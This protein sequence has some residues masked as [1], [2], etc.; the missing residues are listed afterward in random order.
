KRHGGQGFHMVGS[1]NHHFVRA[2]PVH[3]IEHSFG[4]RSSSPS[5]P[6][7]GNL[8]GMTRKFQAPSPGW[9]SLTARYTMISGG[10]LLSLPGQ[11]GQ[12]AAPLITA[13][14]REKSPGRRARSVD[15]IT[16]R[17]VTGSLR[18]SGTVSILNDLVGVGRSRTRT[19]QWMEGNNC[20]K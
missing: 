7:A 14:S 18:S 1:F 16:Q 17:P 4:L 5:M 19:N 2:N 6:S 9:P 13:R 3:A 12:K 10:V 11:N 8:L 15:M 20:Q